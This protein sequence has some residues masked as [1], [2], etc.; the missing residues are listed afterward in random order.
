[1]VE[2]SCNFDLLES[3]LAISDR[4]PKTDPQSIQP[5]DQV[6]C[7]RMQLRYYHDAFSTYDNIKHY[8]VKQ[9]EGLPALLQN[10]PLAKDAVAKGQLYLLQLECKSE[11]IFPFHVFDPIEFKPP[12]SAAAAEDI[13]ILTKSRT[14]E[15]YIRRPAN[16]FWER[17]LLL[18]EKLILE[19]VPPF[20]EYISKR[21]R[22][23]V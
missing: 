15:L 4:F 22:K 11:D 5:R 7:Y 1:M 10:S 20:S 21:S 19:V 17:L 8:Q 16:S 18:K 6:G 9:I 12:D 23:Y 14:V 3:Y 2:I 13:R